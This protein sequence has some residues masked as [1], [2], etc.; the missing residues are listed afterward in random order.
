MVIY[1]CQQCFVRVWVLWKI[2]ISLCVWEEKEWGDDRCVRKDKFRTYLPFKKQNYWSVHAC[3]LRWDHD[4]RDLELTLSGEKRCDSRADVG[5]FK[6]LKVARGRKTSL[7]PFLPFSSWF[8]F[9]FFLSAAALIKATP[10]QALSVLVC[11]INRTPQREQ[12]Q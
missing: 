3:E 5:T 12:K 7:G 11:L 6:N 9:S 2:K 8:Y 4:K 10:P 1:L